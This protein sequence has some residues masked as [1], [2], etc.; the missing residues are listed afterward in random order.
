[1][2]SALRRM[3]SAL[4]RVGIELYVCKCVPP[5]YT[6]QKFLIHAELGDDSDH[7]N[8]SNTDSDVFLVQSTDLTKQSLNTNYA[9]NT[10]VTLT[11]TKQDLCANT[12]GMTTKFVV[13]TVGH[14]NTSARYSGHL[15]WVAV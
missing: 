10:E 1:M 13:V 6:L 11:Q 3:R 15:T 9:L 8:S 7:A 14:E 5:G 2:R 12:D 4:R